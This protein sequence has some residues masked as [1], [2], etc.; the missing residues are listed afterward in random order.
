MTVTS[1][2]KLRREA[3]GGERRDSAARRG[4]DRQWRK[5]RERVLSRQ[6]LCVDC[7]AAGRV[8]PATEVHHAVKLRIAPERKHDRANLVPLCSEC[9]AKRT[10]RGE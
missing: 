5:T 6:P 10:A 4:Y 9:H 7:E 3:T 2:G 8:T 1:W